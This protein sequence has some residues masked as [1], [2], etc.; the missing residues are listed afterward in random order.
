MRGIVSVRTE[1]PAHVMVI[2]K[3][4]AASKDRKEAVGKTKEEKAEAAVAVFVTFSA[5][6]VDK[7]KAR[8]CRINDS[9]F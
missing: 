9:L 5:A 2:V 7:K 4:I 6:V 3:M 1:I 8:G